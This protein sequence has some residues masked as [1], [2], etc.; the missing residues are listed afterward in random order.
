[1]DKNVIAR[2]VRAF[3]KLKGHTQAELA[4]MIG[5]SM[6]VLGSIERGTRKPDM[7]ILQRISAILHVGIEELHVVKSGQVERG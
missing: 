2:R 7:K 3:R 6:A 5:V 4:E 1:M